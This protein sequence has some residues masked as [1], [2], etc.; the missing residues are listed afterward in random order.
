[1]AEYCSRGLLEKHLVTMIGHY[2]AKC[3]AMQ[4]SL[5]AHIAPGV[6]QWTEPEGGYFFWLS[7]PGRNTDEIFHAAISEGVA[8][9]PGPAFYP[10]EDEQI[11]ETR[12]GTEYARLAFTF[13]DNDAIDEGCA[14]LERAIKSFDS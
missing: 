12:S 10:G 14:R 1:V 6:A 4:R 13:A 11:G 7:L 3:R 5:A 8:F 9:V 2:A